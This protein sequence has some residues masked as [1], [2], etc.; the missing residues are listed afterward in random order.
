MKIK[1][2]PKFDYLVCVKNQ[3]ESHLIHL[4]TEP[5]YM[6]F[7]EIAQTNIKNTKTR[8]L[9][10]KNFQEELKKINNWDYELLKK[11][12]KFIIHRSN[13]KY[14]PKLIKSVIISSTKL[15]IET[16]SRK[17]TKIE[18]EI[19]DTLTFLKKCFN[20]ISRNFYLEP[21]LLIDIEQTANN[22][23]KNLN[24]SLELIKKSL[25]NSINTF[26]PYDDILE[27]YL[28]NIEDNSDDSS[29]DNEKNDNYETD[30]ETDDETD[31]ETDNETEE[32]VSN[33]IEEKL[34]Y[35]DDD[36]NID[37]EENEKLDNKETNEDI[38]V[39]ETFKEPIE[40]QPIEQQPI[41]QPIQQPIQ[42]P[43]ENIQE[44]IQEPIQEQKQE[45]KIDFNEDLPEEFNFIPMKT[46][47][48]IKKP[49]EKEEKKVVEIKQINLPSKTNEL[50]FIKDVQ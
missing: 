22:R 6:K 12:C 49:E 32:E 28:N 16:S 14:I 42:Q 37:E 38:I 8:K 33:N 47:T 36:A 17:K 26:L 30:N 13:S 4:L 48:E 11:N 50:N 3:Y 43:K 40:Q 34:P 29:S 46:E 7:K 1:R 39:K 9:I 5:F 10:L 27:I 44:P 20:I 25:Y 24:N 18:Y 35:E 23:L 21:T 41:E 19:P 31:N 15:L 45:E 2:T